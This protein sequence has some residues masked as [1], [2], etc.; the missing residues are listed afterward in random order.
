MHA[1]IFD[2]SVLRENSKFACVIL[3][4][5]FPLWS[6]TVR[7]VCNAQHKKADGVLS[8][9]RLL[10]NHIGTAS[11]EVYALITILLKNTGV[12]LD[13]YKMEEGVENKFVS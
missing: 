2:Q 1:L 8:W 10:L 4:V 3:E 11:R 13:S 12:I 6:A 5:N 7:N 9:I